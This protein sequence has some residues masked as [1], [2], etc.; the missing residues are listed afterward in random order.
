VMPVESVRTSEVFRELSA[1]VPS[2]AGHAT[3]RT[4]FEAKTAAWVRRSSP[5]FIKML[6][7]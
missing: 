3:Q 6:D 5:S 7:T 2:H 4:S 1:K